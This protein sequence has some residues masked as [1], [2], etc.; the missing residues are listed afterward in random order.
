MR[1]STF[2]AAALLLGALAPPA[3][4]AADMGIAQTAGYTDAQVRTLWS[5]LRPSYSGATYASAPSVVAPY[6]P[7]AVS[8]GFLNDGLKTINFARFLAGVPNDVVLDSARNADAQYGAVLL[9]AGTF[10]HTPPKP[11][12]MPQAFYDRGYASTS[13]SNIGWGYSTS[14]SFEM[15]CLADEDSG[16]ISRVGHRR[17]LL[18]PQMLKTGIGYAASRHTT[19]AFDS[20]RATPVSYSAIA[21]P[22]AGPFPVDEGFFDSHTPWSLTLNPARYDWDSTGHTVTLKRVSD[23]TTW[24]FTAAD[25]NTSGEFFAFDTGGY[26]VANAFIFR[27]NPSSVSYA[28]GDQFDVT[29]SGGIYAEGTRT[30]VTVSYRTRFMSLARGNSAPVLVP[31][32][33]RAVDE[34]ETLTLVA[35]ATD[36]DGDSLSYRLSGAPAGARIDSATGAFI[37]TPTEAQGPGSYTFGVIVSDGPSI[38]SETITVTVREVNRAPSGADDSYIGVL[39]T[40]RTVAAPGVLAN[41]SDPDV[42]GNT[43]T[44]ELMAGPANGDVTLG[45]DG[46][47][48]YAPDPGYVGED[49][50]AYRV[51]DGIA[52][53]APATVTL[54]VQATTQPTA[55]VLTEPTSV[56]AYGGSAV[57]RASLKDTDGTALDGQTIVFDRWSGSG[58]VPVGSAVTGSDGRASKRVSGLKTKVS[59]RARFTTASPYA[60]SSSTTVTVRPKVRLVRT[61]SWKT[62]YRNRTYYAK[63]YIQPRHLTSDANRVKIRAYKKRSDG[64]YHYVRSFTAR[65][66]YYSSTKTGYKA[67]VKFTSRGRWKL[68]AYHPADAKNA[69]SSGTADYVRVR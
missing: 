30:P 17:W 39:D 1:L 41:D 22:S 3:A 60:G 52:V 66:V 11:S 23:G 21:Y 44:A 4:H 69:A 27:P 19:Y 26:G 14:A 42:P 45:A 53:S 38:D 36:V 61:T 47:F 2:L 29:L 63:G 51:S 37:F 16:N 31:I 48:V 65:Y 32:G 13:S 58:W 5:E 62:R 57:L 46:S 40:T 35:S 20:S 25:T 55:L 67:R 59:Y 64:R 28:A 7:G 43:L 33:A 49:S 34:L 50:F 68:V 24:T 54:T 18:N 8:A 12:D 15:G 9:A 10:S 6:A 56:P